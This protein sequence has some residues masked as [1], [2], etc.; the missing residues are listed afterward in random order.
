ML[1]CGAV[2][3]RGG[4][5]GGGG[6]M[7][8]MRMRLVFSF[9]FVDLLLPCGGAVQWWGGGGGVGGGYL[10]LGFPHVDHAKTSRFCSFPDK[11]FENDAKIE[12][13]KARKAW[14][15]RHFRKTLPKN[16]NEEHWKT[17]TPTHRVVDENLAK[18]KVFLISTKKKPP[19]NKGDT[20][21][22]GRRT[23]YLVV[24]VVVVAHYSYGCDD[25]CDSD[26]DKYSLPFV[27]GHLEQELLLP[28]HAALP[29]RRAGAF[30]DK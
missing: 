26:D 23:C 4:G 27:I 11:N 25:D 3:G 22:G 8:S 21:R 30:A 19:K 18:Y 15:L 9:C 13:K 2:V 1:W 24:V 7:T 17:K 29:G 28:G 14:Y 5:V 16:K 12:L 10:L 20:P 6:V